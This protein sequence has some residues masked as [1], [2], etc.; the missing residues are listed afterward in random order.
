MNVFDDVT[1]AMLSG[2]NLDPIATELFTGG[3]KLNISLLFNTQ[4]CFALP[5][6]IRPN[7]T[8]YFIMK[9]LKKQELQQI[10]FNH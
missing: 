10:A 2:K 4:S 9:I 5:K 6:N 3:R 1:V 7:S 8:H